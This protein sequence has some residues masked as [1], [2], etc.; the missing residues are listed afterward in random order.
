LNTTY[1]FEY[2]TTTSYGTQTSITSAGSGASVLNVNAALS[3]LTAGTLYHYRVAATNSAGTTPG[4]DMTFTTGQPTPGTPFG[5]IAPTSVSSGQDFT[6]DLQIGTSS[7]PVSNLKIIS[8]E[9]T[10]T[11][12]AI[13]DYTSYEVGDFLT[14]AQ[15]TVV[16]DDANGKVSASVYRTS[17]GNSG[18]GLI[19]RL[20]FKILSP[21]ID[22][23]QISFGFNTVQANGADGSSIAV[24]PT[25]ATTQVSTSFNVWPGDA[26]NNGAVN[27]FDINAIVA[28]NWGKSG[29]ARVDQGMAWKASRAT[30]WSPTS[31]TY[32][33]CNGDGAVNI[34]DINAIVVN[35]GQSHTLGKQVPEPQP[36]ISSTLVDPPIVVNGPSQ[37]N[38][39]QEFWLEIQVGSVTVP[40]TNA[41]IV[42]L[43]LLYTNTAI[44]DYVSDEL[45]VFFTGAQKTVVAD[46]ANG[47][48]SASVYRT[49]GSNSGYGTILRIKFKVSSLA[50]HGQSIAFSFGGIQ[51]NRDDGSTQTLSPSGTTISITTTT[52]A[53]SPSATPKEFSLGQNYP[54]PFNPSTTISYWLPERASVQLKITNA[55][56]QAIRTF[57]ENEKEPGRYSLVWDG[58]DNLGRTVASGTYF[59]QI[60]CGDYVQAKKMLLLK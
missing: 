15:A 55:F 59:Y 4:T 39:N 7:V 35:F 10:Y 50:T 41:K 26:D 29:P 20:K 37:V 12:T 45:G 51:A 43:E 33:D 23:Q 31:A 13:I 30:P 28:L 49:S 32:A 9:L 34:F 54:N 6:V 14:G 27:I 44:I 25:P 16:A 1:Y 17:G 24:S 3:G 56:G 18:S 52:S 47:K 46:D 19:L 53:E 42:S 5:I 2:G 58:R 60:R 22:G 11:N 36:T 21:A 8:F 38:P 48:I 57:S 40:V